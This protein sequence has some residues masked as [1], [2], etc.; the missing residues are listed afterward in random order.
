[1]FDRAK[2]LRL[3]AR[4]EEVNRLDAA[5]R[6]YSKV[7]DRAPGELSVLRR[8][9]ALSLR[10]GAT[11]DA[12]QHSYALAGRLA[13]KGWKLAAIYR[14]RR[15]LEISE[16][17][18]REARARFASILK[19]IETLRAEVKSHRKEL[20]RHTQAVQTLERAGRDED[21]V[22]LFRRMIALEPDNPMFHASLAETAVRLGRP[23]D[24]IPEFRLAADALL[25]FDKASDA[26]RVLERVLHFRA[27]P[28]DALLAAQLYIERG[29]SGDPVRAISKLELALSSDPE[30][31]DALAL[32]ARAF[33][34][35]S[36]AG[37]AAQVRLEMARIA[38]DLGERELLTELL[39]EIV[40]AM[41]D[42]P[43]VRSLAGRDGGESA[44]SISVRETYES[45][46]DQE[47]EPMKG[48]LVAEALARSDENVAEE[49]SFEDIELLSEVWLEP[50]V[51]KEARRAL[52]EAETFSQ[53]KLHVK[54]EYVL[55]RAIAVDGVCGELREALCTVLRASSD[56]ESYA[57]EALFLAELYCERRFYG[58]AKALVDDVLALVPGHARAGDVALRIG[59]RDMYKIAP[60]ADSRTT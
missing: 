30:S 39:S 12:A 46:I 54:A 50:I 20:A 34:S 35:M 11:G 3:A 2:T 5:V 58:R 7:T 60:L 48:T 56:L 27:D 22:E 23:D 16:R 18:P 43:L 1:M 52:A 29:G 26:L 49:I 40:Q 15:A 44:P 25:E 8:V 19:D 14:Y 55:R 36:Q 4:Y 24:A 37:R 42:D 59:A 6:E 28:D 53:L 17:L 13:K 47:L 38:R 41:P 32:L 51:S 21:L 10:R 31:L 45:A 33:D 9:A 57:E